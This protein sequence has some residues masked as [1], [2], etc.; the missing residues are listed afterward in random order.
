LQAGMN[1]LSASQAGGLRRDLVES[2][3][4]VPALLADDR[5]V[6]VGA[7]ASPSRGPGRGRT[8]GLT[9]TP[10]PRSRLSPGVH[11]T[12]VAV[13]SIARHALHCNV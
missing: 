13:F 8:V 11:V 4:R 5:E 12:P 1:R 2:L 3:H 6:L 10:G 7:G 9:R